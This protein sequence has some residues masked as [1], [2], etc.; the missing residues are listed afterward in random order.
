MP[1]VDRSNFFMQANICNVMARVFSLNPAQI[2]PASGP[3]DIP[4]W[5]SAG[6]MRLILELE[7]EFSVQ[8]TDAEVVELVSPATIEAALTRHC[9]G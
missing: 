8:F 3:H 1:H 5:D 4:T 6:H 2:T 7:Q 9:A